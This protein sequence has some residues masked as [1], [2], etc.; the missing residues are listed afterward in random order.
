MEEQWR[1][2]GNNSGNSLSRNGFAEFHPRNP[3]NSLYPDQTHD[4]ESLFS[5]LSLQGDR[6]STPPSLRV[7]PVNSAVGNLL[8]DEFLMGFRAQE[9]LNNAAQLQGLIRAQNGI[10]GAHQNLNVGP[11]LLNLPGAG[12]RAQPWFFPEPCSEDDYLRL[13]YEVANYN[14]GYPFADPFLPNT[15]PLIPREPIGQFPLLSYNY[16]NN[17]L[18]RNLNFGSPNYWGTSNSKFKYSQSAYELRGKVVHLAKDQQGSKLLQARLERGNI[19][20]IRNVLSELID[21]VGDLMKS[22]PGSY[23]IQKLFVVCNEEQRTTII[24]AIVRNTHQFIGICFSQH[25]YV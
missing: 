10:D 2:P 18:G 22:Q 12:I 19:E 11:G 23:V 24:Q 15:A 4:L 3:R 16:T 6:F 7:P 8:D 9:S 13:N 21:S 14:G 17:Y 20:E 1:M 5:S 25:G